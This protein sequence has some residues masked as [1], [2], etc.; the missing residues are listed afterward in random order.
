V[1]SKS[2]TK[3]TTGAPQ[4]GVN[5]FVKMSIDSNISYCNICPK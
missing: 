1:F 2:G 3:S 5:S 4:E